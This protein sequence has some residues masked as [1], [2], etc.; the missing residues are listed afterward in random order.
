M[1]HMCIYKKT[2]ERD[3][4]MEMNL[5][6]STMTNVIVV[7]IGGSSEKSTHSFGVKTGACFIQI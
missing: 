6:Q 7:E 5:S 3:R 1:W 2:R 4:D